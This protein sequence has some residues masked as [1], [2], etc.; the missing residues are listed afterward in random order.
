[1]TM[2]AG[3][4]L[5]VFQGPPETWRTECGKISWAAVKIT[6]LQDGG[7]EYVN[8]DA[9]ADWA[10]LLAQGKGR[11]AYLYGHPNV[12]A[13]ATVDFFVSQLAGLV[14]EDADGVCL[15]LEETDGCTPAEVDAWA[16][17]VLARIE[18]ELGRRPLLYTYISFATAGNCASLGKYPLWIA[19]PSNPKGSPDVPAPW[20]T[21]AIQQYATSDNID[22]D[23]ANYRSLAAMAAAL[24]KPEEPDVKNIGGAIVGAVAAVRWDDGVVVVAG[25]CSDGYVHAAR[26]DKDWGAW[27]KV[28]PTAAVG[29]PA[30]TAWG[31]ADGRLF[32]AEADGNVCVL[33]TSDGGQN[34][35]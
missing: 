6:E 25:L 1:M 8:P 2:L 10:Y 26:W 19:D 21:W 9:A 23:V 33:E 18:D 5:A 22:R 24:G 32:Y 35:S 20:Q 16:V 13:D 30:L 27:S 3:V 7:I 29:P 14:L 12:G 4:D 34:W 28:S 11:V 31:A 17:R 15:D